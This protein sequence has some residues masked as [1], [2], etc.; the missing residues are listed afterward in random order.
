MLDLKINIP[1][2]CLFIPITQY[3]SSRLMLYSAN[4]CIFYAKKK[5]EELPN[6]NNRE[7]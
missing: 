7:L 1:S 5:I 4:G 3:I 2:Y 6:I